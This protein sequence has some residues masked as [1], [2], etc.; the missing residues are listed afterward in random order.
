M[1]AES[2]YA[3]V[4][5]L[6]PGALVELFKL[7]AT[8]FGGGVE[9]FHGYGQVGNITWQGEVYYPWPLKAEGFARTSDRPPSPTFVVGN[10]D[11]SIAALCMLYDDMV[12]AIL[13]RKRTFGKYLDVV[14]FGGVNPTA[15]PTAEFPLDIWYVERK[16]R[17]TPE[18]VAFELASALDFNGVRLPRRQ[19]I[20]N[21]C[22][23]VATGGYRGPYCGY[24]GG[25][26]AK[27]DGTPTAILGEDRCGGKL[28]D[29]KLRFGANGKLPYGGFPAAG[30]LRT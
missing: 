6:E 26:V 4:Q 5:K 18:E 11:G 27:A 23:W 29:C 30:L 19:I 25:A 2:I 12:G 28:S 17:E 14:N 24:A 13:T 1:S 21:F 9:R 16:M 22:Q 15:D 3:D 20:A 7:D 8:A 10:V